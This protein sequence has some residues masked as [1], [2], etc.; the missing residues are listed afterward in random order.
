MVRCG[1][2]KAADIADRFAGVPV[3]PIDDRSFAAIFESDGDPG[4]FSGNRA[5][6]EFRK[7]ASVMKM[8]LNGYAIGGCIT[9]G[10]YDYHRRPHSRR[11]PRP[12]R[13]PLH[14]RLPAVRALRE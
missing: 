10:G 8:V 1:Y 14:R 5:T 7:T 2:L 3:D 11:K 13:R 9:M 12:A 4:P 6:G